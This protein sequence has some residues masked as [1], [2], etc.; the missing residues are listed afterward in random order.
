MS[1]IANLEVILRDFVISVQQLKNEK[2]LETFAMQALILIYEVQR[3]IDMEKLI[4][5]EL[6]SIKISSC[7]TS[8]I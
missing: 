7:V 1:Y 4:N 5:M 2:I 6:R 8:K 3:D